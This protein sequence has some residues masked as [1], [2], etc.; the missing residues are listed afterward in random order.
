MR[1]RAHKRPRRQSDQTYQLP[2]TISYRTRCAAHQFQAFNC[3]SS[4]MSI[5]THAAH[6]MPNRTSC[7]QHPQGRAPYHARARFPFP[8]ISGSPR[9]PR[10]RTSSARHGPSRSRQ[11]TPHSRPPLRARGR[12][13]H[14]YRFRFADAVLPLH[15]LHLHRRLRAGQGEMG[16]RVWQCVSARGWRERGGS[17]AHLPCSQRP[18]L[19]HQSLQPQTATFVLCSEHVGSSGQLSHSRRSK[20]CVSWARSTCDRADYVE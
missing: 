13:T 11:A 16:W 17:V 1:P 14:T 6:G 19:F 4:H 10:T 12:K 8:A 2:H 18:P 20:R 5:L 7:P 15:S 3:R 9:G